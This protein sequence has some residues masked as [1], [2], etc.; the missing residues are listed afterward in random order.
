MDVAVIIP[1]F[2]GKEWIGEMLNTVRAQSRSPSEIVVVD[3]EST[4]SS[5]CIVGEY[6]DMRL[7]E[8]P[9]DGPN[10]ARNHGF[11]KTGADVVAFLDQ[12]DL[13]HPEHLQRVA[14]VL[15]EAQSSPVA[16][17]RKTTIHGGETPEYPVEEIGATRHDP[18]EDF[19]ANRLGE[20]F[21]ALIRRSARSRLADGPPDTMAVRT[22]ICGSGLPWRDPSW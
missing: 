7:F 15:R 6:S 13:W 10:A 19:P 4:D 9:G 22:T 20:P 8:N 21:L 5:R 2:N 16:F 14:R 11:R 1:L 17:A 12:D 3:D 18:W